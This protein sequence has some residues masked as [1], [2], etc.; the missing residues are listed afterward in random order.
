MTRRKASPLTNR[1]RRDVLVNSAA[2]GGGLAIGLQLPFG[3]APAL[4]QRA[5]AAPAPEI[6][7]W[8]VIKPDDTC[9]I[10]IARSEMG[11]GT[12]TGLAQL[13]V[14]E[15][16]CDWNKVATEFPTPGESLARQRVWGEF[17][18]GGS[19]GIRISQ[20]YVRRGG[21]VARTMLLQAA[22][23]E[24]KVPPG[25]L[26]VANGVITHGPT[27]RKTTYGNV[28]PLA[29]KKPAYLK[30]PSRMRLAAIPATSQALAAGI[31][32]LS[33]AARMRRPVR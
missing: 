2:A 28:A 14:E 4:A 15:L 12:L 11:Q 22:A 24:W 19:R 13:V 17:G 9:V 30:T 26:S 5:L 33:R 10:R 7:A 16:E 25:E 3:V 23:E 1:S 31:A 20:D 8:V 32:C 21:A 6:N 27:G 29:A 18:T